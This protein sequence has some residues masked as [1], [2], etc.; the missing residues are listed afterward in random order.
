M[1]V[2][3]EAL[4]H[5]A[6]QAWRHLDAT[7]TFLREFDLVG[8]I[9]YGLTACH[10]VLNVPKWRVAINHLVQDATEAPNVRRLAQLHE[11]GSP[12]PVPVPPT[13]RR[14][15]C[16]VARVHQALRAH[17]A[18][19]A[20]LGLPVYVD[21]FFSLDGVRDSKIDKF[22]PALDHHEVGGLEVAVHDI[23]GMHG[24]EAFEHFFP[25]VSNEH[26]IE[27]GALLV[28]PDSQ[29][30]VEVQFTDLHELGNESKLMCAYQ[31]Y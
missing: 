11:L 9:D 27:L 13:I 10:L 15:E 2:S 12:R 26:G 3:V 20:N 6:K 16:I 23:V 21:C 31:V 14:G 5:R 30:G 4:L 18:G 8:P 19:R 17:V 1:L 25:I 24:G 29:K 28:L 7:D 22:Q